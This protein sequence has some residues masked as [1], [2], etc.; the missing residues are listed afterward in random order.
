MKALLVPPRRRRLPFLPPLAAAVIGVLAAE[1]L[2]LTPSLGFAL[3]VFGGIWFFFTRSAAAFLGFCVALFALLHLWQSRESPAA[4]L[5]ARIGAAT[6]IVTAS[7]I[8]EG[9][10]RTFAGRSAFTLRVQHLQLDDTKITAPLSLEIE[11]PA[12]APS[13]GEAIAATGVLQNLSPPRNPG[14]FDRAAWMARRGVYSRI[15]VAH[16]NDAQILAKAQGNPILAAAL[17]AR[18]WMRQTLTRGLNDPLAANLLVGMTLGDTTS[19]PEVLREDFRGTGTFHLFAVSGLHV[20]ILAVL[21]WTVF[22]VLRIPRSWIAVLIILILCF[23]ALM[24][25][26]K[27]SNTRATVMAIIV[28]VGLMGRRQ[29]VLFNNLLAAAFL[30]LLCD[31]N[32]LF[33][34]GFQLSFS[35]VAAI[36]FFEPRLRRAFASPFQNDPLLPPQFVTSWR[37]YGQN[38]G[39]KMA[40]LAAVSAA[41]WIGSLPLTLAYF[42]LVSFSAIPANLFAVPVAF[43]IMAVSLLSL[44]AASLSITLSLIFNQ[45]NWLLARL[46][47][48]GISGLASL[49]GSFLYLKTPEIPK[50]E[51]EVVIFDFGSGGAAWLSI[52]GRSWLFDTGPAY[53]HDTVLLPFLH[54]QGIRTLDGLLI[55]HG[56]AGHIGGATTVL[57][58][59]SPRRIVDSVLDDHSSHRHRFHQALTEL[60]IPKSL[61]RTDDILALSPNA[62][63][64]ILHP[65]AGL[66]RR[67]ADEKILI[68]RVD[69][70]GLRILFLSD[71]GLATERWLLAHQRAEL[72]CDILV[73][74]APRSGPSADLDFLAA[75]HPKVI[76]AT[77]APFPTS[78]HLSPE[79][80]SHLQASGIVLFRQDETGAVTIKTSSLSWQ[81]SAFLNEQE[82]IHLREPSPY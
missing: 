59:F 30:I 66:S 42:H 34:P 17:Q 61:H 28:L 21:L 51:A 74:G 52:E 57:T 2:P 41:A 53:R 16:A 10:V 24:T 5:A 47:I 36:L 25:G 45:T 56:D 4:Q 73:R 13:N 39:Q 3:A 11:W 15:L 50:P 44:G 80:V 67:T 69:L 64:H 38:A 31:T 65:P 75:T 54:A 70:E 76:I 78:E 8:V 22:S 7:G 20:G 43:A 48:G 79:L 37:R 26:I 29:P 62:S 9:E 19:M 33:N 14:Q 27:P 12:P 40:A 77:A 23:Y 63:L 46:L 71:A 55:S 58:T 81:V 18:D 1:F 35:V 6:P 32:Q 72:A 49:P 68:V 60:G 82:Y